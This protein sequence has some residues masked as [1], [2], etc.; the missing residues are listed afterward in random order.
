MHDLDEIVI[1]VN[2]PDNVIEKQV[3]VTPEW[4]DVYPRITREN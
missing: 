2:I 4:I 3:K 1:N